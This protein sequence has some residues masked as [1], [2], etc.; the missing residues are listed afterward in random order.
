VTAR[1]ALALAAAI[2]GLAATAR[3]DD[4][5][6]SLAM[7][8]PVPA[9]PT[10]LVPPVPT[11]AVTPPPPR[12]GR[13]QAAFEGVRFRFDLGFGIDGGQLDC[14]ADGNCTLPPSG[15][16]FK[17][18]SYYDALRVYGYGDAV[19]ATQGLGAPSLSSYLATTFR[20]DQPNLGATA[21]PSPFDPCPPG[22]GL[23]G[24]CRQTPDLMV[25]SAWAETDGTILHRRLSRL[26]VRAGRQF[27]Y[28]PA[29]ANF[30]GI[31]LDYESPVLSVGVWGGNRV[32]LW[33]PVSGTVDAHP[34]SGSDVS[35]D[36]YKLKRVP[37]VL[38]G[39]TLTYDG[40]NHFEA[41]L[42]IQ[43]SPD[44][45][46][47]G[48]VRIRGASFAN[49]RLEVRVRVSDVTTVRGELESHSV[50]DWH[51]DLLLD[52]PGREYELGDPRRW[53]D[54]GVR[55]PRIYANLRAGT[56]LLNNVDV[57]LRA[58]AGV[59]RRDTNPGAPADDS[60]YLEGGMAAE[61][62]FR[63]AVSLGVSVLGRTYGRD[64]VTPG[65]LT[66]NLPDE[67]PSAIGPIGERRM[68]E[69]GLTTRFD[70]GRRSMSATAEVYG[71][72]QDLQTPYL[73]DTHDV[74]VRG[75]ARVG[76]DVWV[77]PKLRMKVEYD[78]TTAIDLAPELRGVKSLRA[79]AEGT[80]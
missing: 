10:L 35:I 25:R 60:S 66:M 27:R 63:R 65:D 78:V 46:V 2:A 45:F 41:G 15:V 64:P 9:A 68:L 13:D 19:V 40:S 17:T 50:D 14:D 33:R 21:A 16:S 59:D 62:R 51:Y 80:L 48:G 49:Q 73:D 29:I 28:G 18:G 5:P 34:I 1:L 38:S 12:R 42:A 77:S 52:R 53:L 61:I 32:S 79:A 23:D 44:V 20:V 67:L 36:M 43:W 4:S 71:R 72:I 56:V 11:E 74:S 26:R 8:P 22:G 70:T 3:A 39:S 6:H 76:I 58:G 47:R 57:L 30:D 75:G 7:R 55:R 24:S 31:A 54:F 37:L 69:G